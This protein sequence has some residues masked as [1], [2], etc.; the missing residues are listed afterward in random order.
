MT[1]AEQYITLLTSADHYITIYT[2]INIQFSS[3]PLVCIPPYTSLW[4][5]FTN[6]H[7]NLS[8]IPLEYSSG[9]CTMVTVRYRIVYVAHCTLYTVRCTL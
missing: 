7:R 3:Y 1:T 9:N 4:I 5:I 8:L 6:P 2:I